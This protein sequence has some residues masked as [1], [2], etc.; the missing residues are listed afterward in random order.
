MMA[1]VEYGS[2][3][4]EHAVGEIGLARELPVPGGSQPLTLDEKL[5]PAAR[6][7][8]TGVSGGSMESQQAEHEADRK[9]TEIL[10][11]RA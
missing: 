2:L 3:R 10:R 6:A 8:P 5:V 11:N 4:W 7:K 9:T 1:S